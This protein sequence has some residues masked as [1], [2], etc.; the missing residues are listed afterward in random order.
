M[1]V[2]GGGS[3]HSLES[4]GTPLPVDPP[5]LPLLP[6]LPLPLPP[7]PLPL[8]LPPLPLPLSPPPPPEPEPCAP[9]LLSS[10][11]ALPHSIEIGPPHAAIKSAANTNTPK[12]PQ[13]VL[14]ILN[15]PLCTKSVGAPD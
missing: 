7:L 11:D 15:L 9:L 12:A 4:Q 14:I 2:G 10:P 8:R 13:R 3:L 1:Q 5:A 6:T